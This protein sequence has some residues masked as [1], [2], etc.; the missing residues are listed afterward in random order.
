MPEYRYSVMMIALCVVILTCITTGCVNFSPTIPGG[1][2]GGGA[3]I[4]GPGSGA[5]PA[6]G[7][8]LGYGS[9]GGISPGSGGGQ[10]GSGGS[11]ASGCNPYTPM[12]TYFTVNCHYHSELG[13]RERGHETEDLT[14][15]GDIPI[16]MV[17]EWDN[18]SFYQFDNWASAGGK[19]NYKFSRT[20]NCDP[21]DE[22]C[23]DCKYTYEGPAFGSAQITRADSVT[24]YNWMADFVFEGPKY[25]SDWI[26]TFN[27][28]DFSPYECPPRLGWYGVTGGTGPKIA[29]LNVQQSL[30]GCTDGL[31]Q[32]D[33]NH[34]AENSLKACEPVD[35]MPFVLRD[36]EVITY[37]QNDYGDADNYQTCDATYTFH[38]SAR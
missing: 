20:V 16:E 21:Y 1:G 2:Q 23:G 4:G 19:M 27:P 32:D 33:R 12:H 31:S 34:I 10:G 3:G 24:I 25:Y 26:S 29:P 9:G 38:I 13:D 6:A 8:G 15:N 7:P 22:H 18:T 28:D 36:G 35:S 11:A 37:R 5:G 14:V 17:R 30:P